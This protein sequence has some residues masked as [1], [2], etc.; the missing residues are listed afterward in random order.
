MSVT[1]DGEA[2]RLE[3][4]CH[5]EAAETLVSLIEAHPGSA[6]DLTQCRHLHSAVVQALLVLKPP[7][8][9]ACGDPFVATWILPSQSPS[10]KG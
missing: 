5:V 2:I 3:G 8:W 10:P 7:R 6:V 9:G 1:W 4:D